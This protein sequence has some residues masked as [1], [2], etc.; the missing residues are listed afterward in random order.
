M[1]GSTWGRATEAKP[2][3]NILEIKTLRNNTISVMTPVFLVEV[4]FL[5]SLS[6]D[7]HCCTLSHAVL[8][9]HVDAV[10][11]LLK[12]PT[13]N[14]YRTDYFGKTAPPYAAKEKNT[15]MVSVLLHYGADEKT[16][17][18]SQIDAAT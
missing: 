17:L 12:H 14:G 6:V 10:H 9:G 3:R 13:Y 7:K 2:R 8:N 18:T 16:Q 15:V 5:E 4:S 1:V 11:L